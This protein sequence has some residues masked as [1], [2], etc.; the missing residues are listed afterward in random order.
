MP[1]NAI[2]HEEVLGFIYE[3]L[4]YFGYRDSLIALQAESKVPYNTIH[5]AIGGDDERGE[6][7][8]LGGTK[9]EGSYP[10][11]HG[12]RRASSRRVKFPPPSLAGLQRA[13][14]QGSWAEVLNVYVDGLLIPYEVRA[15]LY[16]LIFEELLHVHGIQT[17]ARTLLQH[18]PIFKEMHEN[19]PA[20][21]ARL[22]KMLDE[23]DNI[24]WEENKKKGGV[25]ATHIMELQKRREGMFQQLKGL[26][27]FTSDPFDGALPSALLIAER[28]SCQ[29]NAAA[30]PP[31]HSGDQPRPHKRERD[32][33]HD[34]PRAVA[35]AQKPWSEVR[36]E[37]PILVSSS[38]QRKV[39]YS[40]EK[41]ITTC[42][43]IGGKNEVESIALLGRA[44]GVLE[45]M[46]AASGEVVGSAAAHTDGVLAL[47]LDES[48]TPA[49]V[50]EA[51]RASTKEDST[52]ESPPGGDGSCIWVAVG[53]RDGWIKVYN[54]S[55]HRLVRR[56]A[57]VHSMGVTSLF[58]AGSRHPNLMNHR[59]FVITGSY[60][61]TIHVLDIVS[62]AS[63]FKLSDPHHGTFINALCP[64]PRGQPLSSEET[65]H[66]FMSAGNDC[67]VGVWALDEE[68]GVVRSSGGHTWNLMALYRECRDGTATAL[69]LVSIEGRNEG[70]DLRLD[71][72]NIDYVIVVTRSNFV[73]IVSI[74]LVGSMLEESVQFHTLCVIHARKRVRHVSA[75]GCWTGSFPIPILCMY[76]TDEEGTTLLYNIEMK[77]LDVEAWRHFNG[78][79]NITNATDESTVVLTDVGKMVADLR[80]CVVWHCTSHPL[81]LAYAPS[82]S[83]LYVLR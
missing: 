71:H 22:Q 36:L 3:Y 47:A 67:M 62:G 68:S 35:A 41:A 10:G 46:V 45:F 70:S 80:I 65:L 72:P 76:A 9:G 53:Y 29:G 24:Q 43:V 15:N 11:A 83:D 55:T 79:L 58:F 73:L 14:L 13:V 75:H 8:T 49:R 40:A 21:L 48:P 20:R 19:T 42:C 32:E 7:S 27:H 1:R 25:S 77:W 12:D 17:A 38:I 50:L 51:P 5:V 59:N 61:T 16:E 52:G 74:E 4:D 28:C 54:C 60:D 37:Y 66:T 44:D 69:Q 82:L 26:I 18:S 64:L 56:F 33:A 78:A 31:S 6:L 39:P 23:F 2:P 63:I 30:A 57:A 81:L 34:P